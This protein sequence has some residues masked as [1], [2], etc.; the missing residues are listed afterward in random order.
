[1]NRYRR[2]CRHTTV[3]VARGPSRQQSA[4]I[5]LHNA[6][7]ALRWLV[8]DADATSSLIT[9]MASEPRAAALR[10][11]GANGTPRQ[12]AARLVQSLASGSWTEA[13]DAMATALAELAERV[14]TEVES[15]LGT[16]GLPAARSVL[17]ALEAAAD[18][19]GEA[20]LPGPGTLPAT[21]DALTDLEASA[22]E[23]LRMEAV[24][25]LEERL[26][27][28]TATVINALVRHLLGQNG[29]QRE[30][31]TALD[32]CRRDLDHLGRRLA[33][34]IDAFTTAETTLAASARSDRRLFSLSRVGGDPERQWLARAAERLGVPV[35]SLG[36]AALDHALRAASP[37]VAE[38]LR[39]ASVLRSRTLP[40]PLTFLAP[41][42]DLVHDAV[43]SFEGNLF[44]LCRGREDEVIDTLARMTAAVLPLDRGNCATTYASLVLP[45][46]RTEEEARVAEALR[47]A[48]SKHGADKQ[49]SHEVPDGEEVALVVVT[50]GFALAEAPDL[51]RSWD[52]VFATQAEAEQAASLPTVFWEHHDL[53]EAPWSLKFGDADGQARLPFPDGNGKPRV[54]V[55]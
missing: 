44:H 18:A 2:N 37:G 6:G 55:A 11:L 26:A 21:L 35:T 24:R 33:G 39:L 23:H 54:A 19:S 41:V 49:D 40:D 27:K 32:R 12:V 30:I 3:A 22:P 1:M 28:E 15:V 8:A 46:P 48:A 25:A 50:L 29:T 17:L 16:R 45:Q 52:E 42:I 4:L 51:F 43:R 13:R 10:A 47:L 5:V 20:P 31:R 38:S 34:F 53:L 14:P 7:E 36:A 9:Q